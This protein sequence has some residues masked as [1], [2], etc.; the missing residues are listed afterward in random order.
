MTETP[1]WRVVIV[2]DHERS[3]VALR[4]AIWAAGGAVAGEATRCADALGAI[5][6]ATPDV[7]IVAVG[8]P[9]GDGVGVAAY[10]ANAG[11]PV[12]LFTSHT[13]DE[14]VRRANEAGVMG[15]LVKPLRAAELAPALDIAVTRFRESRDLRRALEERKLVERAKGVL[16]ARHGF[17]EDEAFRRLRRAAMDTRRPMVEVARALLV[18]EAVVQAGT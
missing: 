14:L 17:T 9:D 4:A 5:T 10:A 11:C 6:R 16:M 1:R 18:S 12:V 3:R 2:D 13:S 8:L 7:A 15:Y